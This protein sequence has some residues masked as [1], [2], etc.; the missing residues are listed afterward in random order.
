MLRF[1]FPIL[2]G[3][4]GA[5]VL[6]S[7]GI[8]QLQRLEWKQGVLSDIESRITASPVALPAAPAPEPD[9]YLPVRVTGQTGDR[10][11]HVLVSQKLQGAG[12]RI[13][14]TLETVEGRTILLDHGFIPASAKETERAPRRATF[15][16]TSP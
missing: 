3:L 9:R 13:I 12:F 15:T 11:L 1:L 2:V 4:G 5:A 7:L 14:T 6:G 10:E 8:W 16:G